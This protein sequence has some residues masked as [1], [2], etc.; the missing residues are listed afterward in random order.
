ML[1]IPFA[2]MFLYYGYETYTIRNWPKTKLTVTYF[3]TQLEYT[4]KDNITDTINIDIYENPN[5][6]ILKEGDLYYMKITGETGGAV[7]GKTTVA[8]Y[9]KSFKILNSERKIIIEK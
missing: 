8:S 5:G 4:S 7:A 9:V 2:L 1:F 6:V 3:K